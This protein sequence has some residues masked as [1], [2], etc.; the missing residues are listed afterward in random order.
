MHVS[1]NEFY[2]LIEKGHQ[3]QCLDIILQKT[4][5]KSFCN[6]NNISSKTHLQIPSYEM[7]ANASDQCVMSSPSKSSGKKIDIMILPT[8]KTKRNMENDEDKQSCD[9]GKTV[10]LNPN[11]HV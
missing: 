5:K 11:Q 10:E 6:P 2:K 4:I 7:E 8:N 3:D 1:Q 9:S